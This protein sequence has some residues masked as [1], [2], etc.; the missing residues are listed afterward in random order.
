MFDKKIYSFIVF[1]HLCLP[2]M[3]GQLPK[4]VTLESSFYFGKVV[5]H[6][7]KLL[8]DSPPL[9]SAIDFHLSKQLYGQKAWHQWMRFPSIGVS[10][11]YYDIDRDLLGK[12]FG[13]FPTIDLKPITRQRFQSKVQLGLGLAYLT[14]YYDALTNPNNNAIGSHVNGTAQIKWQNQYSIAQNWQVLFGLSFTHYSNGSSQQPNYGINIAAAQ[15]GTKWQPNRINTEGYIRRDSSSKPSKRLGMTLH[16]GMAYVE[17]GVLRG[18]RYPYYFL[19]VGGI[20]RT[21]KVNQLVVGMNYEYDKSTYLWGLHT[22]NAPT[23][24][25][26]HKA[27]SRWSVFIADEIFFGN[28]S[29][30]AQTGYYL[31]HKTALALIAN[32]YNKIGLRY[33]LP[34]IGKPKTR[35][36]VGSYLKTHRFAAEYM[37]LG[38]GASF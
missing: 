14:R 29:L 13:L 34:P 24:D 27:A 26:A 30:W 32:W 7:P 16:A 2:C 1:I 20:Y 35:F 36:F 33:Y 18:P 23:E 38:I 8:F 5:K 11:V 19:S 9:S 15:F 12:A 25:A 3:K 6:T 17:P 22:T 31:N 21:S 37:G 28:I 10:F 4:G